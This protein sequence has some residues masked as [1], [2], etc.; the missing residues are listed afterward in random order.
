MKQKYIKSPVNYA[1]GKYRLLDRIIPLFPE[2]IDTFV[3][4]FGGAFNVGINVDADNIVYND[5]NNYL[6]ILFMYF[7]LWDLP[8][9]NYEIDKII[10]DNNLSA[11]DK[12][13]FLAFRKH[14]NECPQEER[15]FHVLELFVLSCYSFN[16]QMR[17]NSKH[18]FNSSFG[19]E[20][21]TMNPNIRK[22]LNEFVEAIHNK[23]CLFMGLDFRKIHIRAGD[24]IY[25][26]PP[27]SLGCGVYQDG[28]R[29]F[30]GWTDKD[31]D[32]LLKLMDFWDSHGIK[33][34]MSN[35]FE[36][37]G[38]VNEKL[39]VWSEKYNVHHLAMNY[40][41]ANYHRKPGST[42]E[43]LITNYST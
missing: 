11:T 19:Y 14:W 28:K 27:Y 4:L 3:D 39:I 2:K 13:A 25:I 38:L 22:N 36:N 21:S 8:R 18:E 17:F 9:L 35:V 7:Q 6:Q 16:Y 5:I 30:S 41:N 37:K 40:S 32:D 24:F 23:K 42:D 12:E 1:G 26:D 31:D 33:W 10:E 43:V 34:A 20:D 15:R 29:G